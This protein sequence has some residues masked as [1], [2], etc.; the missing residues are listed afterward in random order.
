MGSCK[1]WELEG[2]MPDVRLDLRGMS[3]SLTSAKT[4]LRLERM[5][6]GHILELLVSDGWSLRCLPI[7]RRDDGH[8]LLKVEAVSDGRGYRIW[9]EKGTGY[10]ANAEGIDGDCTGTAPI[11][12]DGSRRAGQYPWVSPGRN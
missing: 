12:T 10:A 8:R 11:N 9:M 3:D 7:D 5:S 4:R 2:L 1:G 6:L